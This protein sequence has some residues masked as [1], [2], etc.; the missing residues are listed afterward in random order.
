[1]TVTNSEG[2]FSL[3][4]HR[5]GKKGFRLSFGRESLLPASFA[6]D[7]GSVIVCV[8]VEESRGKQKLREEGE[9]RESERGRKDESR[10]QRS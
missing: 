6:S 9:R 8:C 3:S 2:D 10:D 4:L 7:T 1:M 5:K